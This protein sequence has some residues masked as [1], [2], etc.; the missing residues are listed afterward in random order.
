MALISDSPFESTRLLYGMACLT[1]WVP[2][3]REA[4]EVSC[5]PSRTDSL[6]IAYLEAWLNGA[7]VIGARAG[8][9]TEVI[10]DGV[11]G[12]LVDFHD[13]DALTD[14]IARLLKDPDLACRFGEAGRAKVLAAHT[15][16]QRIGRS[17]SLYEDLA[18][19]LPDRPSRRHAP[20]PPHA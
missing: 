9:V 12:Y 5:M 20:E 3:L 1:P 13:V 8:G 15:W 18:G 7:P 16:D 11:D 10:A 2:A 19:A 14:R 17:T 4:G 6:G